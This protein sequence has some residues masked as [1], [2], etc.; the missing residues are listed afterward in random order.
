[1]TL[2]CV[3]IMVED[4]HAALADAEQARLAGADIVEFR[5][6]ALFQGEGDTEGEA[7]ALRLCAES[8]LPCIITCRDASEGGEY[9][10]DDAA[11]IAL[12]ERLGTSDKP[13]A[14]LDLEL[15]LW[16][17]SANLRQ[18]V[19]L[20]VTHSG[21]VR[22]DVTTRLIISAHDFNGRPN[23]LLRI[24]AD[25]REVEAAAVHKIAYRARSLR[26]NLELFDLLSERD[27]PTIALCMGEFGLMSRVLAPKFGGFLTFASL[28][29]E[30]ATAPGQPT[31]HDLLHL[32]RFRAIGKDTKVYG[33]IGW[34]VS[35]SM[36]PLVHNAGFEAIGWD[37]VYLPLPVVAD[38][39]DPAASDSSFRA[40]FLALVENE[41]VHFHGASVTIPFKES[42]ARL[43][44]EIG[45]VPNDPA[46]IVNATGAANTFRDD[47]HKH[48]RPPDLDDGV[49]IN[50]DVEGIESPLLERLDHFTGK[51]IF[52][53]GAGGAARA[54]AWAC[55]SRGSTV[56]VRNRTSSTA[57]RL[58]EDLT[59]LLAKDGG[60]V[61]VADDADVERLKPDAVINCTP[62]GMAGGPAEGD[63]PIDVSTL[64]DDCVVFDT[65]YNPLE[66]PLL[67]SARARG[68]RTIDG[69][70]M[71]VTQAAAQFE[72][73]TS[74][75][76]PVELF[77][78]IVR[79]RLA[80]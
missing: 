78:R 40:S 28:R 26:D 23:D 42:L 10:G 63:S 16:K 9:S 45:M 49:V 22:E 76:A 20:A 30:S 80:D 71:F 15:A 51:Q 46:Y 3:P 68:L 31:I 53:L 12:Y 64:P 39:N 50:S 37:G 69:V 74:Q 44:F 13:P 79:E 48:V 60:R 1:M 73:W 25:L 43:A 11:K 59:P 32:Y 4:V 75:P 54:A 41:R 17:R 65:V 33:V 14:Y 29:D 52:I 55:A 2:L 58:V 18:K 35:H 56:L 36:S 66:T 5:I 27:R 7:G 62:I 67:K 47:L 38:S 24:V 8:P 21:Q 57:H 72:L 19:L 34:P 61:S 6:D 70:E 77:E